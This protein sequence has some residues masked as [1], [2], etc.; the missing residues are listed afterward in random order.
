MQKYLAF[1]FLFPCCLFGQKNQDDSL[2][3]FQIYYNENQETWCIYPEKTVQE[4]DY[5]YLLEYAEMKEY[6]IALEKFAFTPQFTFKDSLLIKATVRLKVAPFRAGEQCGPEVYFD[7]IKH[8]GMGL[9]LQVFQNEN[10]S[11]SA[12]LN[13]GVL[14][15]LRSGLNVWEVFEG[16]KSSMYLDFQDT[17]P[18]KSVSISFLTDVRHKI[19]LPKMVEYYTSNDGENWEYAWINAFENTAIPN[20][21]A[22]FKMVWEIPKGNEFRHLM[23]VLVDY[24]PKKEDNSKYLVDEIIVK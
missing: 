23:L 17:L 12:L 13:D 9:P 1:F 24:L 4:V 5:Q 16:K 18:R 14:G 6:G 19:L 8:K 7:L 3:F 11:P 21:P 10:W 2:S 15:S 20:N 22:I